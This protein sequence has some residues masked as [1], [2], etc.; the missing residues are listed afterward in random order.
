MNEIGNNNEKASRKT[1]FISIGNLRLF[2][3][4]TR[5]QFVIGTR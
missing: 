2:I 4:S 3:V 5:R 1:I